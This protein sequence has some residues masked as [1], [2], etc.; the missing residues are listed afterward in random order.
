V[1]GAP[2]GCRAHDP[3]AGR[4][5]AS[6]GPPAALN[7]S[8]W[9]RLA[10]LRLYQAGSVV[11]RGMRGPVGTAAASGAAVAAG[12]LSSGRRAVITRHLGRILGAAPSAADVDRAF[13][14]YGRYWLESFR[15]PS[16]R[17]DELEAGTDYEGIGHIEEARGL[18]RG[19]IMAMPHLGAWDWGGAWLSASGFPL[20][21][22]A[23]ELDPPEL[24][25]W[26][27][28]LRRRM[29]MT[30][31]RLDRAAA[32]G[33]MAALH[34]GEVVGLLCDRDITGDG[35]DVTFFGERTKLPGGPAT[36]ALRTGAAILPCCVIF[37]GDHHRAIVLPPLD[38]TR[39]GRLR[40][41]VER[42]TQEM[43]DALASLIRRVPEQWHVFQP[44]WPSD[45][46][47]ETR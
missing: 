40:E 43:A 24:F 2:A 17:T 20:T 29:G 19:V 14:S 23:E 45:L 21:V 44:N 34:R 25:E 35:I 8:E 16:V 9:R 11:A 4:A 10:P 12:R 33:V 30:V 36:L 22:V 37:E 46:G 5:V 3:H 31:V 1:A 39:R 32:T 41:D 13:A 15:L 18:G 47:A 28:G 27:A 6:P 38:T 42:I 26:F 7:R